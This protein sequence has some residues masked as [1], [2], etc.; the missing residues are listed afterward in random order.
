MLAWLLLLATAVLSCSRTE[1]ESTAENVV[2]EQAD[3]A[4]IAGYDEQYEVLQDGVVSR[5]EYRAAVEDLRS[6]WL[7]LNIATT[8]P[9][10][11][12]IDGI[13]FLYEPI[14]IGELPEAASEM[15]E[16]CR[17]RYLNDV[18]YAYVATREARMDAR[19]MSSIV[20][21]LE[22]AGY[23]TSGEEVSLQDLS[24]AVGPSGGDALGACVHD[25]LDAL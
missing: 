7:Q 10:I 2:A 23:Q 21:C 9:Y 22:F 16:V 15:Q 8:E 25:G 14:V 4:R 24:E 13:Q 6:C 5:A 12:P 11:D 1:A 3:Q 17:A 18:E 20:G 19:L